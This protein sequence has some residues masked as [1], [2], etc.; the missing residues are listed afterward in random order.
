MAG[1]LQLMAGTVL[2]PGR[3]ASVD[4]SLAPVDHR[5]DEVFAMGAAG[6]CDTYEMQQDQQERRVG[7]ELLDLLERLSAAFAML[8]VFIVVLYVLPSPDWQACG[9]DD[10]DQ[11]SQCGV[12]RRRHSALGWKSPMALVAKAV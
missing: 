7:G 3:K 5:S 12:P 4:A 8:A 2:G 6:P 9:C 1:T 10:A 11:T